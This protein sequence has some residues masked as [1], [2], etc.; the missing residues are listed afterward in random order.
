MMISGIKPD[1][2]KCG[3]TIPMKENREFI[4]LIN[5]WQFLIFDKMSGDIKLDTLK[6]II[7]FENIDQVEFMER[8]RIYFGYGL[9]SRSQE[10]DK[11]IGIK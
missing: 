5:K 11:I 6:F 8:V 3:Y 1:C 9:S 7:E 10:S 4:D 2:I